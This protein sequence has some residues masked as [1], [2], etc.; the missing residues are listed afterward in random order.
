M[1]K[2]LYFEQAATYYNLALKKEGTPELKL[3][4]ADTYRELR[5]FENSA[6]FY[7]E[8]LNESSSAEAINKYHYAQVLVSLGKLDEARTWRCLNWV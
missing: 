4:L 2:D 3:K 8:A 5:D 1:Y 6:R 7:G